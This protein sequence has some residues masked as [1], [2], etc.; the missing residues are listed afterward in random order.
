MVAD[1]WQTALGAFLTMQVVALGMVWAAIANLRS[2]HRAL[3]LAAL[4][5]LAADEIVAGVVAYLNF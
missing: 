5:I 3:A 4:A 2:H 1:I